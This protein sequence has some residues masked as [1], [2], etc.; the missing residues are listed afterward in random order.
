MMFKSLGSV[1]FFILFERATNFNQQG[2]IKL[3]KNDSKEIYNQTVK[4]DFC[5]K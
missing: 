3:I 1:R 5:S 2:H 4:K